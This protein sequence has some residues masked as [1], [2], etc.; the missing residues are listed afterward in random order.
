[1]GV[2]HLFLPLS[3]DHLIIQA[4]DLN[5]RTIVLHAAKS[6]SALVFNEVTRLL[7][8]DYPPNSWLVVNEPEY[9]EDGNKQQHRPVT[10]AGKNVVVD[11]KGMNLLHHWSHSGCARILIEVTTKAR[12][13]QGN[14][15]VHSF[16]RAADYAGRTPL[17]HVLRHGGSG[18]YGSEAPLKVNLLLDLMTQGHEGVHNTESDLVLYLT[19]PSSHWYDCTAL[20]HAAHGG[21]KQL[22]VVREKICNLAPHRCHADGGLDL[23]FALG[24]NDEDRQEIIGGRSSEFKQKMTRRHGMLLAEAA[25]GGHVSVIEGVVSAIKVAFLARI[26]CLLCSTFKMCKCAFSCCQ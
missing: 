20:M 18:D 8:E 4:R 2:R 22:E 9:R 1:M 24:I 17:M 11:Y 26:A 12:E 14:A 13:E 15:F 23:N 3:P 25:S 21:P 5:G 6:K 16:L 19:R 10:I 7:L